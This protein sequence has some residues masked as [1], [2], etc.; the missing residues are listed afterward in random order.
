MVEVTKNMGQI[1]DWTLEKIQELKVSLIGTSVKT[2]IDRLADLEDNIPG[3]PFGTYSSQCHIPLLTLFAAI[4]ISE[5]HGFDLLMRKEYLLDN[6]TWR[7]DMIDHGFINL[8]D[9][10][11]IHPEF[12]TAKDFEYALVSPHGQDFFCEFLLIS[13]T[14]SRRVPEVV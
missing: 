3:Y 4:G 11:G 14:L 5:Q 13:D 7:D 10:Y 8:V 9:Y 1:P 6:G 12:N 2:Q